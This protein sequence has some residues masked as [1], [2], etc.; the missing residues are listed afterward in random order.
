MPETI[1]TTWKH[2]LLPH[3]PHRICSIVGLVAAKP[4]EEGKAA[5]SQLWETPRTFLRTRA[6]GHAGWG[7]TLGMFGTICS[8][9]TTRLLSV[10]EAPATIAS[11]GCRGSLS[12]LH[13]SSVPFK[14]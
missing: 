1:P 13:L 6:G 12:C 9:V 14:I 2:F 7:G 8:S 5:M 3:R 11:P 4:Q 10:G